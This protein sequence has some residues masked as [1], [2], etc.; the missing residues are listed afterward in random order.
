MLYVINLTITCFAEAINVS[1]FDEL[2][3]P[4]LNHKEILKYCHAGIKEWQEIKHQEK[5]KQLQLLL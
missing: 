2:K 3:G 4:V 1:T 5:I